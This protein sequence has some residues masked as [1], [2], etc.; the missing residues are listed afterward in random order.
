MESDDDPIMVAARLQRLRDSNKTKTTTAKHGQPICWRH[1]GEAWTDPPMAMPSD[2][3]SSVLTMIVLGKTGDGK[4]SLLND[5]IGQQ[6]FKQKTAVK[7]QTK[8]I[9]EFS[10]FWAPLKPYMLGKARF[11]NHVQV[12]DTPGFGD[13][14]LRDVEFIPMIRQKILDLAQPTQQESIFISLQ[15]LGELMSPHT[16]FWSNV[17]LVFTHADVS[18]TQRYQ[19][20]KF[21][22]KT[23]TAKDIQE[24]YGLQ[25]ELPMIFL[26]T[27][28]YMCSYIRGTGDCDCER[29]NRY[30]ADCRRRLFEQVMKRRNHPFHW[31]PPQEDDALSQ[32]DSAC[33]GLLSLTASTLS[34]N[35]DVSA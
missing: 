20:H 32:Q 2:V 6:V 15:T 1:S 26:S 10:G 9:Q 21:M 14:Q 33:L 7:S 24:H 31:Y 18:S 35:T 5:I 22:L 3:S 8:V 27:Q 17:I 16:D 29:G 30:N 23:K 34:A 13:S 28:K 12:I 25:E 4:S 11:G 19:Q